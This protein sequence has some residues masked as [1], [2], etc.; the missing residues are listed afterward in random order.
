LNVFFDNFSLEID[1]EKR[2]EIASEVNLEDNDVN[3]G[4]FPLQGK[5]YEIVVDL[6]LSIS[7]TDVDPSKIK[8]CLLVKKTRSKS[9][10][11]NKTKDEVASG[12]QL[13]LNF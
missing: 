13:T 8:V 6:P 5:E 9:L 12:V 4:S 3:T 10:K 1:D 2:N 11:H 7:Q